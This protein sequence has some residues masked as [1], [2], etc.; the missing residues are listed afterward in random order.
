MFLKLS[1]QIEGQLREAYAKK[2]AAG[3]LN[4]SILADR[5][6]VGR[7]VIN[8]RLTGQVN[9]TEETIADMIWGLEHDFEFKIFDPAESTSNRKLIEEK[10]A[11]VPPQKSERIVASPDPNAQKLWDELARKPATPVPVP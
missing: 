7:S 11:P 5:L 6:E 3:V 1:G 10:P 2:Y 8:R 4:Q 9:M